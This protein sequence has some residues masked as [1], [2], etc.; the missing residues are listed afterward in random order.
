M[1][2]RAGGLARQQTLDALDED[3]RS[4]PAGQASPMNVSDLL[5]N[6]LIILTRIV[7]D[8]R[9]EEGLSGTNQP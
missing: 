4:P 9:N 2:R 3:W 6:L 5:R 8:D 1:V 7:D